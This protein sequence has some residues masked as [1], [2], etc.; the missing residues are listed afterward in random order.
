MR[1]HLAADGAVQSID[2]EAALWEATLDGIR[3]AAAPT[4]RP[5]ETLST[6][7]TRDPA[8]PLAALP[9]ERRHILLAGP[10]ASLIVRLPPP[11]S[12]RVTLASSF[13]AGQPL[14]GIRT[15]ATDANAHLRI[16]VHVRGGVDDAVTLDREQ[17]IDPAT[18]LLLDEQETQAMGTAATA[19]TIRQHLTIAPMVR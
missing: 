1:V 5:G 13:V 16:V 14:T 4:R 2:D 15:V 12:G 18:G 3:A 8:A 10:L 7:L 19:Q 9:P 11:S 6:G 17:V